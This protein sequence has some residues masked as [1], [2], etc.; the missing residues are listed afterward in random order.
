MLNVANHLSLKNE[1]SKNM[2]TLKF[3]FIGLKD[4]NYWKMSRF[5]NYQSIQHYIF[6]NFY[7]SSSTLSFL[8]GP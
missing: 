8:F 3:N 5:H 6:M 7:Y 4:I 2:E 1:H